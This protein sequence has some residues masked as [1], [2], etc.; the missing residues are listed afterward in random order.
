MCLVERENAPIV[1]ITARMHST[2][3]DLSDDIEFFKVTASKMSRS[4]LTN[5]DPKMDAS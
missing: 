5:K 3:E 4:A 1:A 2:S